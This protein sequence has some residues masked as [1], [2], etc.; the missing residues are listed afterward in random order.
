MTISSFTHPAAVLQSLGTRLKENAPMS[1]AIA[2]TLLPSGQTVK[3]SHADLTNADVGAIVNAANAHLAHGGGVAGAIVR[4]GGD[5]IQ[6]ESD[7]W[8]REHGPIT[9]TSPA[10]T[11]A[12]SLPARYVIHA[13]GPIWGEGDEEKKLHDAV[14]S[15]LEM[16]DRY[17]ISS[18]ALPAISTGIFGFPKDRGAR[19]ILDAIDQFL[20]HN[21]GSHLKDVHIVL[22]DDA[23]VEIFAGEFVAR[24]AGSL[25]TK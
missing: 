18:V 9:H 3:L 5:V 12:G 19:V 11:S 23:S 14:Y 17:E 1:K 4:R 6:E 24:W 8:V 25:L 7:D 21:T 2:E 10:I 22:I 13:V 20:E 15:A 16:A